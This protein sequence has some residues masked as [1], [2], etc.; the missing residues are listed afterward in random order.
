MLCDRLPDKIVGD[1][2][3]VDIIKKQKGLK[4]F[5]GFKINTYPGKK[6]P[7]KDMKTT[8]KYY[9]ESLRYVKEI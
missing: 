2:H 7:D 1:D 3:P 5:V 8:R 9:R 6:R 4:N